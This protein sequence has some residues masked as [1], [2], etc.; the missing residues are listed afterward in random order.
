MDLPTAL[1]IY[2]VV[3]ILVMIIA[4]VSGITLYSSFILAITLGIL[5]LFVI[6]PVSLMIKTIQYHPTASTIYGIIISITL[7]STIWYIVISAID[8]RRVNP[9]DHGLVII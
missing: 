1:I 2:L 6:Y 7:I 8:D 3:I 5:V 9:K 4:Y